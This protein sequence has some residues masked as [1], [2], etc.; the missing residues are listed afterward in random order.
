M[1]QPKARGKS[2]PRLIPGG[3]IKPRARKEVNLPGIGASVVIAVP[4]VGAYQEI[5]HSSKL[6]SRQKDIALA[7]LALVEPEMTAEQL[8]EAIN[9]WPITDWIILDNAL[10]DLM[11]ITEEALHDAQREFR[12]ANN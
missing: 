10:A 4:S 7:A 8:T 6:T 5:D 3:N 12:N 2:L 11:G 1:A 9:D